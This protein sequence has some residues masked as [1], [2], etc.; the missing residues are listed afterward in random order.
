MFFCFFFFLVQ[1]GF[2]QYFR[3][4]QGFSIIS[5]VSLLTPCT[6][7]AVQ[8]QETSLQDPLNSRSQKWWDTLVLIPSISHVVKQNQHEITGGREGERCFKRWVLQVLFS[9][10]MGTERQGHNAEQGINSVVFPSFSSLV[11]GHNDIFSSAPV[12][13]RH[14]ENV[15]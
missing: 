7:E 3:I 6:T 9:Q 13:K 8:P 1:S 5:L 4:A 12:T 10:V 11:N 14:V 2:S 15:I